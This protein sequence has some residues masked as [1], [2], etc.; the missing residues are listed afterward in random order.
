MTWH[1]DCASEQGQR[2]A[3]SA[4]SVRLVLEHSLLKGQTPPAF[5]YAYFNLEIQA[6]YPVSSDIR[7][8]V[9]IT[10]TGV[11]FSAAPFGTDPCQVACQIGSARVAATFVPSATASSATVAGR[12]ERDLGYLLCT[13][14]HARHVLAR[15]GGEGRNGQWAGCGAGEVVCGAA[16]LEV[17]IN[18][19]DLT[20]S[21][22]MLALFRQPVCLPTSVIA[23]T[24]GA[25]LVVP[26][27]R[28]RAPL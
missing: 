10:L 14:P 21:G 22:L 4:A 2:I 24:C 13:T 26:L 3:I 11:G 19:L 18:G 1:G 25:C 16:G 9:T 6:A 28:D 5:N 8:G 27:R 23:S 7:G 12:G 17:T 20:R 15:V